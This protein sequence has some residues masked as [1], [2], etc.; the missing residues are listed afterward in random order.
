MFKYQWFES[1][2]KLQKHELKLY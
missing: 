1:D 2:I